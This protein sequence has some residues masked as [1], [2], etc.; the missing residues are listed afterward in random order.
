MS[1]FP[2]VD[3]V[4]LK[5][6]WTI[7]HEKI[8]GQAN[9]SW[10]VLNVPILAHAQE[11]CLE[12]RDKGNC[13]FSCSPLNNNAFHKCTCLKALIGSPSRQIHPIIN[14]NK[15]TKAAAPPVT[16][17]RSEGVLYSTRHTQPLPSWP[18]PVP[19]S[20]TSIS[21]IDTKKSPAAGEKMRG[22]FT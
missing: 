13:R 3:R 2:A 21:V 11:I 15:K 8:L 1:S 4:Y 22:W 18:L 7:Q 10:W 12:N 16:F 6:D 14:C 5:F 9:N 17:H 19:T 20:N